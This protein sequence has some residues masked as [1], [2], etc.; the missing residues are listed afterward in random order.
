MIMKARGAHR[1]LE[2]VSPESHRMQRKERR[3]V[4][5]GPPE[6]SNIILSQEME[7]SETKAGRSEI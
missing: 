3:L 6:T 2:W 4:G 1:I 5:V 7:C